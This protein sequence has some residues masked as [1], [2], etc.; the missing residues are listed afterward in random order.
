MQSVNT[1]IKLLFPNCFMAAIDLKDAYYHAPIHRDYQKFLRVAVYVQGS[2]R[3][4][5]Y[6][7]LPFGL[8]IAP[9]IFTKLMSEV[10]SFLRSRNVGHHTRVMSDNHA[11]VAYIDHQGGTRSPSLMKS[12]SVLLQLAEY[13]LL[14]FSALHISGVEN[15]KADYLSRKT[16]RQGEWSLNPQVFQ[17]I[18]QA[19]GI[20]VIDL[21][22]TLNNRKVE[23]FC[24]LDPREK[25]FA[26]D[27]LQIQWKFSLA[28]IFPPIAMIPA[29]VGKIRM[30]QARSSINCDHQAN[31]IWWDQLIDFHKYEPLMLFGGKLVT[32]G[33]EKTQP[34]QQHPQAERF[35]VY[36]SQVVTEEEFLNRSNKLQD[37]VSTGAF[38]E[39]CQKKIDDAK[40]DFDKNVWSFLKVNFEDDC[41]GKY[42]ELLGFRKEDL[43]AKIASVL[44][45]VDG[46]EQTVKETDL[47]VE[48]DEDKSEAAEELILGE[49]VKSEKA[50]G[51]R[52]IPA[53]ETFNI[54][55]S[56][57]VD[58]LITQALLTGNFESAV[59]LCLH[60]NRMADA[61]ILAIAG[62][63]DLLAK[64]QTKY[65]AKSQSKITR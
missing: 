9:R 57:D 24:S 41:R 53:G 58:G 1:A 44:S 27:A 45:H 40:N 25:P 26:V 48:S 43:G 16:L 12:A 17:Q 49:N 39:Y 31:I 50:E 62:G 38:L 64:T 10:M 65:F 61:I 3:H 28:Y 59:D 32:F 22:A 60:D 55:V 30:D 63:P 15:T 2:L 23:S 42:L 6:A 46:T 35:H 5:Q 19:W 20:P 34:T 51:G 4:Y 18:V 11:V 54:S 13:H 56:G 47:A 7:A 14:S 29:V 33:A 36:V 8:S 37:V 52:T 21:F